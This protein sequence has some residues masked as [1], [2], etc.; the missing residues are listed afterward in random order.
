MN[1]MTLLN[2]TSFYGSDIT[3]EQQDYINKELDDMPIN[4]QQKYLDLIKTQ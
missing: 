1:A 2:I 3:P 4:E